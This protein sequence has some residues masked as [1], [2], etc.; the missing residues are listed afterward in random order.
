MNRI[1]DV[2]TLISQTYTLSDNNYDLST[3]LSNNSI[4][5]CEQIKSELN[6][7]NTLEYNL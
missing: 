3:E 5:Y 7:N 6:T 4:L 1:N 2:D